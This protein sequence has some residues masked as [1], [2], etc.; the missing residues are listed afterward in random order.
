[1][2]KHLAIILKEMFR[3]V[4]ADFKEIAFK[5]DQ[6]YWEY[7]WSQLEEDA[8]KQWLADYIYNVPDARKELTTIEV[9]SKKNCHK[10]AEQFCFNYGWKID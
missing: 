10:F 3:I 8:F 9:K 5:D 1:M 7:T 6:W 2:G 4:G